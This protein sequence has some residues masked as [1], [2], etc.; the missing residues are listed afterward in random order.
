MLIATAAFAPSAAA[1]DTNW[2]SREASPATKTR[3]RFVWLSVPVSD[4]PATRQATPETDRQ[5][6]VRM[7]SGREEQGVARDRLAVLEHD[8]TQRALVVLEP[9]D[10]RSADVDAVSRQARLTAP[11]EG[12]A[13]R[14]HQH[15]VA[16]RLERQPEPRGPEPAA[17]HRQALGAPLPAVAVRAMEDRLAVAGIEPRDSGAIVDDAGGDEQVARLRGSASRQHGL[18]VVGVRHGVD[19]SDGTHLD[20][21]ARQLAPGAVQER[22][23][24]HPVAG[25]IPVQVPRAAVA[26]L[27]QI[28]DEHR[29]SAPP[30]QERRAEPRWSAADDEDVEHRDGRCKRI[31]IRR[32]RRRQAG[33]MH[34]GWTSA[35][36]ISSS[37]PADRAGAAARSGP[38]RLLCLDRADG[39]LTHTTFDALPT[40][41]RP[42]DLLVVNNTRVFPARLIG[43]R[44]PSGGGVECLLV[45]RQGSDQGLTGVRPWSDPVTESATEVWEALVHPGQKLKPGARMVFDGP[46]M[47]HPEIVER[48]FHGRRVVRLWTEDGSP[49]REAVDAIGR[50]P[51]PPYI[52]RAD[53]PEDRDRYQTVFARPR[54]SVAAPTAGLHFTPA[55]LDALAAR[56]VE[57]A[58][59]TLHV[60]YGTFQ[61]V[62]VDRVEDH[63]VEPEGYEIDEAAA[64][65]VNRALDEGRRVIAVG[66]TTT[67]ALEEVA[68]A[69]DG[70]LVAG[71]GST[72]LFIHPG[73][74]FR[75]LGGLLTN[76]HLPRSSL[77][78]LVAAFAG[79]DRIRSAYDA[80]IAAGYR[81][82]SYGDAM[83]IL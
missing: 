81:F 9:R 32:R 67:R 12:C 57:R 83:L 70:R 33:N 42:G 40:W 16:P 74:E 22:Q 54:G 21:V 62:R 2:T 78:M 26:R 55:L 73:F 52:K 30:E 3:G 19:D 6:R 20:A 60:G 24:V 77:L 58:E 48:H 71:A 61:P 68:R 39:S 4:R 34:P 17:Q 29:P 46:P 10:R 53:R 75:V 35:S 65:S 41:L 8:F 56:G 49:V 7:L 25:Q 1:T 38:S 47:L 11:R 31:A 82:Y 28:T 76:F 37:P 51:L 18:V 15:I 66:T 80:A 50:M 63:H 23:R 27:T 43:R 14:A 59:I 64:I 13:V 72:D 44:V 69:H 36:S 79:L 5:V 45:A